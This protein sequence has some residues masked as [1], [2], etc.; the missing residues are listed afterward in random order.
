LIRELLREIGEDPNREGLRKTP[1][2]VAKLYAEILGGYRASSELEVEFAEKS[3]FVVFKDIEFY[4]MCEH[5]LL[6][7]YGK[8]HVI[9]E[10]NGKVFGASKIIR[11]IDKFGRR[12]QI[13][14]R[15][16]SQIADE[17]EEHGAK[18]VLVMLEAEHLC[19]KMRGVRNGACVLTV[20]ERGSLKA[21]KAKAM[22]LNMLNQFDTRRER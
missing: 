10:P 11:L 13:Q 6:P 18:G 22:A 5:H 4:S 1:E 2:R 21:A 14:E 17:L 9:Y 7:F 20:A 16:T 19:M 8:A 12:L 15:M 3:K